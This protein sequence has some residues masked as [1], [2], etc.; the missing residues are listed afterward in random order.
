MRNAMLPIITVLGP[1]T[2]FLLTGTFVIERI[3]SINGLGKYFVDSISTAEVGMTMALTIVFG[4][5]LIVCNFIVDI[6][7]GIVDPRIRIY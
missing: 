4:T 7:Y 3:F 5:F 6:L 2:A 1:T